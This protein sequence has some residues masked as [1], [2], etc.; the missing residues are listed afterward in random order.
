MGLKLFKQDYDKPYYLVVIIGVGANGSHFFRSLCQ[1]IA[2][3][4]GSTGSFFSNS[5]PF[6][7]E[8]LLVDED[9]VERK[10][11]KNQL[12]DEEDIG[13]Y[14]VDALRERYGEHYRLP[15]KSVPKYVTDMET[16]QSL[17]QINPRAK[18]VMPILIGM[19]DNNRTRQLMDEFFHSDYLE[20]LIYLDAGVEGQFVVPGK[21]ERQYTDEEKAIVAS[22]GFSGQVVVGYKRKG[23]IWLDPV[24][25]VFGDILEDE[26]T[27][28][29]NQSCGAAIINNPQRCATNKFAAQIANNV[30]NTIF[31]T[32]EIGTH[33][34]DFNAR[35]CGANPV[36]VPKVI[37]R[38]YKAFL[39]TL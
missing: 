26:Q 14:K 16:M 18:L 1:D 30:M 4:Y 9:Q 7:F 3:Y 24:G 28:F 29:P 5:Y 34:V 36:Y 12:F 2:T 32:K 39:N 22:S 38:E 11:M 31:H 17:F 33:R 21:E 8:I 37:E 23:Q 25:R 27:A 20:D 15:I 6:N 19:V 13:E 10:N 35:L